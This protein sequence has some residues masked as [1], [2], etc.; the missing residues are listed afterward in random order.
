[1]INL[2]IFWVFIIL[3]FISHLLFYYQYCEQWFLKKCSSREPIRLQSVEYLIREFR[4]FLLPV[5]IGRVISRREFNSLRSL[6]WKRSRN[7]LRRYRHVV[8]ERN[9]RNTRLRFT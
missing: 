5:Y 8:G 7:S 9:E 2:N 3:L 1:M 6:S 4:I